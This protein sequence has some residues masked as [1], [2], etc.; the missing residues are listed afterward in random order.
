MRLRVTEIDEDA[1]AHILTTKPP[2]RLGNALLVRGDDLAQVL[3]VHAGGKCCG[4]DE[5]R[6]HHCNLAA[7]GGVLGQ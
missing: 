1:V 7:L 3:R 5:V 2:N 4:T 6:E